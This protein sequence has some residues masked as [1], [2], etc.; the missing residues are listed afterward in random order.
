MKIAILG[1]GNAGC[2][3]AADLSSRNH[4]VTL[5]K[6]SHAVHDEN[7]NYLVEN[8]GKISIHELGEVKTSNIHCVTRDLSLLSQAEVVIIYIQTNYHEEL[9]KK[10]T[11]YF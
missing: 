9:I 3:V 2:A 8:N 7:F 10:I 5:I 1:A 4:E 6:T 11:F